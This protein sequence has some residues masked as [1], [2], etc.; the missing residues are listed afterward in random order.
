M[1]ITNLPSLLGIFALAFLLLLIAKVIKQPAEDRTAKQ[2]LVLLLVGLIAMA[3]CFFTVYAEPFESWPRLRFIEIGLVYWIGPSLYFYLRRLT[4]APSPFANLL[5]LLHWLPAIAIELLLLPFFLMSPEEKEVFLADPSGVYP[6]LVMHVWWGFH[7]Q[8]LLYLAF[9]QPHL[10]SYRQRHS[11][12]HSELSAVNLRWLQLLCYG[13]VVQILAE[14]LLPALKITSSSLSDTAAMVIYVFIIAVTWLALGQ[15]RLQLAGAAQPATLTR[16]YYRSGLRDDSARYHLD[17]LERL[18]ADER[19]YLDG[20]LS[21]QSLADRLKISPH[22]LSQI[23]NDKLKKNFYDYV[24][25]RR[26]EYAK[27]LLLQEPQLSIIDIAFD[28]GYNSR[29]SFYNA[30]R[31]HAG[32]TPSDYRRRQRALHPSGNGDRPHS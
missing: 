30:F 15:S 19:V 8:L 18:M 31:R 27:Q 6:F 29:N 14:R 9:C 1:N 26:V 17:K 12:H 3:L 16:K 24:N 5:N 32:M 2:L 20:E 7:V 22:H 10:R 28:S 21:L 13:F 4:G 25:E 23:L 11:E